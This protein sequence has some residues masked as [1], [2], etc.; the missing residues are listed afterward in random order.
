MPTLDKALERF[1][2]I[3]VHSVKGMERCLKREAKKK[4]HWNIQ[5]WITVLVPLFCPK[6]LEA[7]KEACRGKSQGGRYGLKG[8]K[9]L[10][11]FLGEEKG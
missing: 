10:H 7:K 9:A 11:S 2:F 3:I 4:T 6:P 5:K 1:I 8:S